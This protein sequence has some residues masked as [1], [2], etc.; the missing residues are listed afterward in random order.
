MRK[1]L[2]LSCLFAVLP[3]AGALGEEDFV[4]PGA[5]SKAGLFTFW[6]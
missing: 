1:K 4:D 3:P 5:L 2:I 6:V